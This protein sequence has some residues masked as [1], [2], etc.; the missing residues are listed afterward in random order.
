MKCRPNYRHIHHHRCQATGLHR[1][2]SHL[3]HLHSHRHQHPVVLANTR[4]H[5]RFG[6]LRCLNTSRSDR[7]PRRHLC[8]WFVRHRLEMHLNYRQ[9]HRHLNPP[10]R[11][12]R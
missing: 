4:W 10:I 6:C 12:D 3:L 11:S 2:E 5:Q 7:Q 1:V 8:P 9:P